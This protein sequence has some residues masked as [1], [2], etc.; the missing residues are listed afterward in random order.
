MPCMVFGM[1]RSGSLAHS[2]LGIILERMWTQSQN[3]VE[4][5]SGSGSCLPIALCRS[6]SLIALQSQRLP[7]YMQTIV[8][9]TALQ[10]LLA[11]LSWPFCFYSPNIPRC[12]S[13]PPSSPL[14]YP[15]VQ[16]LAGCVNPGDML[17]IT[18]WK[19]CVFPIW[20]HVTGNLS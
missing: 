18:P 14:V 20:I 15:R 9:P 2:L 12:H 4:P 13:L 1:L 11:T 3:R 10:V 7:R 17:Y 6:A 16:R 5:R 8:S 19:T